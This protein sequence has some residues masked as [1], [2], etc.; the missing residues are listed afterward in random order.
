MTIEQIRRMACDC[1]GPEY[2]QTG[3]ARCAISILL[4]SSSQTVE[5][6]YELLKI[7]EQDLLTVAREHCHPC[8]TEWVTRFS[9]SLQSYG[10]AQ[11]RFIVAVR[12][13]PQH[14]GEPETRRDDT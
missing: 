3:N 7:A 1:A 4:A 14:A 13:E 11:S 12:A 9:M 10:R 2:H 5:E 8:S 6:Q